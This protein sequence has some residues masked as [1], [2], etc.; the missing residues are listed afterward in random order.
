MN[1][2]DLYMTCV[3]DN[4]NC[5]FNLNRVWL[6]FQVQGHEKRTKVQRVH[7]QINI[8]K[9]GTILLKKTQQNTSL[10]VK[11][12]IVAIVKWKAMD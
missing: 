5:F 8:S 7:P 10:F 4:N 6:D 1:D 2:S 9:K 12:Y 11:K 3:V